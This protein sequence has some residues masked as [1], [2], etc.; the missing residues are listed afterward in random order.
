MH[1]VVQIY[2]Y[3]KCGIGLQGFNPHIPFGDHL[4]GNFFCFFFIRTRK[5]SAFSIVNIIDEGIHKNTLIFNS[6]LERV[7]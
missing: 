7:F 1:I 4:L 5:F 3:N 6:D 2:C